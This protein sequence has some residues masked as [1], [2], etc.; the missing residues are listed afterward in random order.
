MHHQQD[1]RLLSISSK[2][3][4]ALWRRELSPVTLEYVKLVTAACGGMA[5]RPKHLAARPKHLAA[6]PKHLAARL[7]HLA[8]RLKHLAAR[9]KHLADRK[10]TR[11]NSSHS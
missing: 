2:M 5:V 6:R 8:A 7:K 3:K 1:R 4:S 9:L 10:S 11:L